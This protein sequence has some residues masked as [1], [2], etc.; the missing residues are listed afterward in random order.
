M[1]TYKLLRIRGENVYPLY[2]DA[3]TPLK[4]GEWLTAKV[5]DMADETHVKSRLGKLS[6][7]P[8][9]HSTRVP[10]ADWIG[11][12]GPD[13]KLYQAPNTVWCECTVDGNQIQTV[14]MNG[15]R[16][17]P[18]GWYFFKTNSKQIDPWIISDKIRIDRIMTQDEVEK[19]CIAH[20]IQPQPLWQQEI[21][22]H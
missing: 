1:R 19:A 15:L 13:G 11:K 5:G 4:I 10:F 3:S 6:L 17:L 16:T 18:D 14:G 2:V 21:M 12:R 22:R 20:G 9:F 7:R 8:G